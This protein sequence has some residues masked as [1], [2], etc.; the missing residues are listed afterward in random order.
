[1]FTL[2]FISNNLT[3]AFTFSCQKIAECRRLPIKQHLLD[4]TNR[5]SM[6]R[7]FLLEY[8]RNTQQDDIEGK[9]M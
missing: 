7:D 1:M 2:R 4:I 9:L 5:V 6:Y 8:Q 3:I